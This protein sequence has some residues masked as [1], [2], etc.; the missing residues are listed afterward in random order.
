MPCVKKPGDHG[1][2]KKT[3]FLGAYASREIRVHHAGEVAGCRGSRGSWGSKLGAHILSHKHEAEETVEQ[4]EPLSSQSLPP[5]T[6]FLPQSRMS[7]FPQTVPPADFQTLEPLGDISHSNHPAPHGCWMPSGLCRVACHGGECNRKLLSC[8]GEE[9][10]KKA[11][12]SQCPLQRH[13][14]MS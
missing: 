11:I 7:Y 10:K 6:F 9:R 1:N 4:R 12:R 8:G 2:L 5:L 14:P 3:E 13:T